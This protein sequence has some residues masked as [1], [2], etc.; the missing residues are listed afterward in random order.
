MRKGQKRDAA[1]FLRRNQT[2]AEQA[3]WHTLRGRRFEGCKFRRQYPIGPFIADFACISHRL[4]IELDGGQHAARAS[5]ARRDAYLAREGWRVLR[6]WNN[7][8]LRNRNGVTWSIADALG[9]A[10]DP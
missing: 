6:F 8:V 2:D 10:F 7:D 5:D 4:V 1:R 3:L 9:I